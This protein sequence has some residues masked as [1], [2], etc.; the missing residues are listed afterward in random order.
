VAGGK[1]WRGM[2]WMAAGALALAA[3][4]VF[5]YQDAARSYFFNDDFQWLQSA[6][7]FDAANFVRIE[8]YDHFYRPVIEIY[9]YLGHR[10]FGCDASSFHLLSISIHLLVTLFVFLFAL[11]LTGRRSFAALAAL[12]FAL[13]PG[14]VEAVAWVGAI[15]DQLPALWYILTLWLHLLFL[16]RRGAW[17]Y[18]L[19]LA[20]FVTCLLTHESS[21]TL[22]VM[23]LALEAAVV[24]DARAPIPWR[25]LAR[26][27]WRYAPF[28]LLLAGYLAIE[29]V[30]N[31]RSYV[32]KE[33]HYRFGWH[34]VPHALDYIVSLYVGKRILVSYVLVVAACAA[35]LV[36]G[37]PRVRFF[38]VWMLVTI[39]PASFFTWGNA[40]RYLY[41]PAAGFALLLAEA[42]MKGHAILLRRLTPR[43]ALAITGVV[44]VGLVARFGVFAAKG[45]H[46]FRERTRP[47]EAYAAALR[48]GNPAP[49]PGEVVY[50]GRKDAEPIPELYREPAARVVFCTDNLRVEIR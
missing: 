14:Y 15:T 40:G 45:S 31:T 5:V 24:W 10:F 23:M 4:V 36:R 46:D 3:A 6:Y 50:V 7:R 32:V 26:R 20:S 48:R 30:V 19:S 37:T 22:L 49:R 17:L 28:V 44:V 38:V 2:G 47:Y 21:A 8:R 9:F 34:A 12:F 25:T 13:Q 27:A 18:A 41:L 39:A 35:L 1:T 33:G 16:Q 43:S 42:V 11:A 29:Y